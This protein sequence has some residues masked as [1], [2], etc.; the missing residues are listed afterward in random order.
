M[1]RLFIA[2]NVSPN[3]ALLKVYSNLQLRCSKGKIKWVDTRLFHLTLKFLGETSETD[4]KR[5]VSALHA[6][7]ATTHSFSFNLKG[8]GIFGSSYRP[9]IIRV[10]IDNSEQLI[11][12]G[13]EIRQGLESLGFLNDRQNFVPHLTL[14][15]IRQVQDKAFFQKSINL[16]KEVF[17]QEVPVTEIV[18]YES[19]LHPKEPEYVMIE[20]YKLL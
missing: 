18:L 1:K 14:G 9:R 20:R 11:L 16:Y 12:L 15:R 6:I 8:I 2:I 13:N 17:F 3:N 4:E 5:I 10:N 7:T 19:I